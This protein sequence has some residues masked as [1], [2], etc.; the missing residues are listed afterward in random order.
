MEEHSRV[1]TVLGIILLPLALHLLAFCIIGQSE[2]FYGMLSGAD[3]RAEKLDA[4]LSYYRGGHP[5]TGYT[6]AELEHLADVK[7]VF[8]GA[9]LLCPLLLIILAVLIAFGEMRAILRWGGLL[10]VALPL[11][12]FLIP[13][14][15]LFT[16]FHGVLFPQGNWMF[17]ADSALIQAFPEGFFQAIGAT[18]GILG[19]LFGLVAVGAS[20]RLNY[21]KV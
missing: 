4:V 3:G 11:L 17:P 19:T 7:G 15:G 12:A 2:T 9:Y 6:V 5:P 8:L 13:F 1:A 18:I 10:A 16:A 20:A 21:H 14:N